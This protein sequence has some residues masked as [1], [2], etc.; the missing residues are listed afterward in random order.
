MINLLYLLCSRAG[1]DLMLNHILH[2]MLMLMQCCGLAQVSRSLPLP[3]KVERGN[4]TAH[5]NRNGAD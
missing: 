5:M 1:R 3:S 2:Q 4:V